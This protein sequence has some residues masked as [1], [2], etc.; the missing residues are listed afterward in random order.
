MGSQALTFVHVII[1]LFGIFTGLVVMGGILSSNRLPGWTA[2]FFATTVLTSVTGYFFH[3]THVTPGQIVGALSLVLLAGALVA[4]YVFDLRGIWRA[5][6]VIGAVASLYLNVFVLVVQSFLKAP[7]LHVLA[8]KGTE[9]PFALTQ[10]VVLLAFVVL[11]I[12]ALLRFRPSA[13]A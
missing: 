1:S 7:A 4:F 11:G 5:V 2:A 13:Q 10:A 3:N 6:Y 9:P 12:F 8:P